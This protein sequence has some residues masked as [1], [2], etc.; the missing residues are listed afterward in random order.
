MDL[1]CTLINHFFN[2][3]ILNQNINKCTHGMTDVYEYEMVS[4]KV[5]VH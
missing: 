1:V 5:T 2:I 4:D 3:I